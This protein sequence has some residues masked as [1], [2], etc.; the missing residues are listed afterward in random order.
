[1]ELE[2]LHYFTEANGF[3]HCNTIFHLAF[4]HILVG[5]KLARVCEFLPQLS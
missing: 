1:M 4:G 2:E 3:L 5:G